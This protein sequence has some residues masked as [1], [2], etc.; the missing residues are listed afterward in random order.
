[1]P[2]SLSRAHAQVLYCIVA[3]LF[4]I[5]KYMTYKP[6]ARVVTLQIDL[7]MVG[8]HLVFFSYDVDQYLLGANSSHPLDCSRFPS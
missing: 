1:M 3:S 2:L 5:S 7:P 6:I 8:F 4:N